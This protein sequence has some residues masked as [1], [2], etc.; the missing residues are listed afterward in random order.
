MNTKKSAKYHHPQL[1]ITENESNRIKES[2]LKKAAECK[3]LEGWNVFTLRQ[4]PTH[5]LHSWDHCYSF[6]SS[7]WDDLL[8]TNLESPLLDEAAIR[9]GFYF[10]SFG[11]YRS[12][13]PILQLTHT[14]FKKPLLEVFKVAQNTK[15]KHHSIAFNPNLVKLIDATF[16]DKLKKEF[17]PPT[18][19]KP[20]NISPLLRQ[21][22]LMGLF[23][24]VSALDTYVQKSLKIVAK[25]SDSELLKIL[26]GKFLPEKIDHWCKLREIL[27]DPDFINEFSPYVREGVKYPIIRSL[28]MVLW[29]YG[30]ILQ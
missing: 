19:N 8:F 16:S 20:R 18:F 25:E 22:F 27:D 17:E 7:R 5:R 11:M 13:A 2:L 12:R 1:L 4:Y 28:D 15:S 23:D 3:S 26:S 24:A 29:N 21:K 6:F 14:I 10:A 30:M 9:L